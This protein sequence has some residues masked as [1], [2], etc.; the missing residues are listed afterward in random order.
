[1]FVF[2]IPVLMFFQFGEFSVFLA[3]CAYAVVPQILLGLNQTILYA[4]SMLARLADRL[5][6]AFDSPRKRR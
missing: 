6:Q 2:L 3:I 5:L 1:M 4:Y